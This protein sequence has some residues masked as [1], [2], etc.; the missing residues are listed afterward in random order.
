M[1]NYLTCFPLPGS[2]ICFMFT[3]FVCLMFRFKRVHSSCEPLSSRVDSRDKCVRGQELVE[4]VKV[5][6]L[7]SRND[8]IPLTRGAI[9]EVL[10]G[11]ISADT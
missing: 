8:S 10:S 9:G 11:N 7:L 5:C 3:L 4:G 6:S 2:D 1:A